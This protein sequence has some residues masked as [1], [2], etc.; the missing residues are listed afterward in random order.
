MLAPMTMGTKLWD[1]IDFKA[2]L[3]RFCEF[4]S[5]TL[6]DEALQYKLKDAQTQKSTSSKHTPI[7]LKN[8]TFQTSPS[9]L[10]N[11]KGLGVG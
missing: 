1:C 4:Y 2:H 10:E 7:F 9:L 3:S 6:S 8:S 5:L 11:E